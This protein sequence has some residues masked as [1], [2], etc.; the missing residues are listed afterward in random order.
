MVH[1]GACRFSTVWH[2]LSLPSLT[3]PLF[4]F[5]GGKIENA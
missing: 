5:R 2:Y 4:F 1:E 3:F